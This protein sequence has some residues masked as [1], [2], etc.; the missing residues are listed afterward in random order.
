LVDLGLKK[1]NSVTNTR[2]SSLNQIMGTFS[3]Y[4]FKSGVSSYTHNMY[5]SA[6]HCCIAEKFPII[7]NVIKRYNS[8]L[9]K[10]IEIEYVNALIPGESITHNAI[11]KTTLKILNTLKY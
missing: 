6:F 8:S 5:I 10:A 9:R 7:G 3:N 2:K 4:F 11:L 1:N